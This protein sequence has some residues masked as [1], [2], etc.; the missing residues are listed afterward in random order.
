MF[1]RRNSLSFEYLFIH[2]TESQLT[3]PASREILA[4]TIFTSAPTLAHLQ[5]VICLIF[6]S[7][8]ASEG[9]DL[10]AQGLLSLLASI[11]NRS[12]SVLP[13][14]ET[15]ALKEAIFVHSSVVTRLATSVS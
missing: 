4:D 12:T 6:H 13:P 7:L 14:L 5:R 11:V 3:D 10:V 8:S 1:S 2:S 9:R 15:V